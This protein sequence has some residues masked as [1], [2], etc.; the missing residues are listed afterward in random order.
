MSQW[1][2]RCGL[3]FTGSVEVEVG[4]LTEG[5]WKRW[6]EFL[7]QLRLPLSN[8][9]TLQVMQNSG[10]FCW[11]HSGRIK[12]IFAT[13]LMNGNSIKKPA[14]CLCINT[15]TIHVRCGVSASTAVTVDIGQRSLLQRIPQERIEGCDNRWSSW[16]EDGARVGNRFWK[17]HSSYSEVA[18]VTEKRRRFRSKALRMMM[19]APWYVPNKVIRG[20]LQIPTV[21]EEI[22]RYSSQYSAR[23]SAHPNDLIVNLIELP[24]NRRLRRH[25]PNDLPTRFLV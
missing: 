10:H 6:R 18:P 20:D 5:Y 12:I 24:D 23:L 19:G 14:Q 25:L 11:A 7:W 13:L 17:S 22:R 15:G 3:Y 21:K 9:L 8:P 16:P 4:V 2:R 1:V